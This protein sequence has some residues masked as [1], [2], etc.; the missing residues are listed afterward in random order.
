VGGVGD[1]SGV[2]Q[3]VTV[4]S[5]TIGG[6]LI[7]GAG[8]GSG[9]VVSNGTQGEMGNVKIGQDIRGG[10]VGG[11]L[12]LNG[13]GF[14]RADGRINSVTVGGSIIAGVNAGTGTLTLSG[15][16][17]AGNDLGSLKVKGSLIGNADNPV[18]VAA[19]GRAEP[20][21]SDVAL[22]S[23]TVLGR[24][25]W[26]NILAGYAVDL[27]PTNG[28]AQIGQVKVGGDWVASN[29]VAGV[30]NT[31]PNSKSFGDGNDAS[32]GAGNASITASIAGVTIG[33]AVFGTAASVNAADHF[34]FVA[35]R[36]KSFKVGGVALRLT[37]SK[38]ALAVGATGDVAVREV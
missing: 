17:R 8:D 11:T 19:C 21:S 20:G 24:V 38:D 32:I 29:L 9:A 26:A 34:G 36:I 37:A 1:H 2:I 4:K 12:S 16:I 35:Q 3:G 6:A 10:S 25:E 14:I 33:G 7:G 22:G 23:L 28:D 5:V 31:V 30:R 27:T 13:S 15:S 18:V